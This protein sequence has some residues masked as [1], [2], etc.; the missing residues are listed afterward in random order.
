[1]R[2]LHHTAEQD[3]LHIRIL[4]LEAVKMSK[5]SINL[6]VCIFTDSTGIVD[7]DICFLVILSVIADLIHD[8]CHNFG[9]FLIHLTSKCCQ[10]VS[11]RA[12]KCI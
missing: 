4:V 9:L 11:Q 5:S 6:E 7:H 3:D 12:A 1:M 8:S 10:A 2:L